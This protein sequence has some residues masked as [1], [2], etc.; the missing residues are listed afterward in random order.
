MVNFGMRL[1][2]EKWAPWAGEYIDYDLLKRKIQEILDARAEGGHRLAAEGALKD[3]FIGLFDEEVEKVLQFFAGKAKELEA[4]VASVEAATRDALA[5][6]L[7]TQVQLKQLDTALRKLMAPAHDITHLLGFISLNL[8]AVRKIL[9]KY[10][11]SVEASHAAHAGYLSLRI[12]HP[13]DAAWSMM[14]GT[15]IRNERAQDLDTMQR[16]ESLVAL[17][18]RTKAAYEQL[19]QRRDALLTAEPALVPAANGAAAA[20]GRERGQALRRS[21]S[22]FKY[23]PKFAVV[24]DVAEPVEEMAAVLEAMA[25]A[26]TLAQRNASFVRAQPTWTEKQAGIFEPPP[27]DEEAVATPL[28]LMLN[29]VNSGL[30]MANYNL[31]IPT[32]T[33]LCEHIG[34]SNSAVGII[35]GCCDIATIPGTL[36]YSIWTGYSFKAPL[37]ASAVACLVGNLAYSLSWDARALW[38]LVLARLMTGLGSA[39]AVNRSYIALFVPRAERTS[40]SAL[41]V[42]LSAIGMAL[43]P[44]L[45]LP[46][47]RFPELT[48]FGLTFN[49]LTMGGWTMN[50]AWLIFLLVAGFLFEEPKRSEMPPLPNMDAIDQPLL[51]AEAGDPIKAA[52]DNDS[53]DDTS[54]HVASA[55]VTDGGAPRKGPLRRCMGFFNSQAGATVCSIWLCLILKV[56]QQAYIDGLPIFTEGAYGW[57]PS[58]CGILLGALGLSAPLVN[59]SVGG[60]ASRGLPDRVITV[61]S[62]LVTGLGAAALMKG[63]FPR[64]TFFVAG[65]AVYMGTIVMEA[66]SMSLCSKVIDERLAKGL[67]NAGLMS[68]QAGTFG[69]FMGNMLLSAAAR[70]TRTNTVDEIVNFAAVL[71]G[72][73]AFWMAVSLAFVLATYRH[74]VG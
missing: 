61:A 25:A 35:I 8:A 68:T 9:K 22:S 49:K 58:Y 29:C 15:L 64:A 72:T 26:R 1:A 40:A 66:V 39:R 44:L 17:G 14:Q 54:M 59:F 7:S 2:R 21:C 36:G 10:G 16:H 33:K 3:V 45:A 12:E 47:S 56:V 60:L 74:L 51:A 48:A 30:Y 57:A 23:T 46:L 11:K 6:P 50:V 32:V 37:L 31:V 19:H 13:H 20:D 38:L 43:G 28:G 71:F 55:E 4:A 42:S 65:V 34:V 63:P 18:G 53:D 27:T 24:E 69:R 5:S 70:V 52:P 41:F 73:A 62:I 67:F